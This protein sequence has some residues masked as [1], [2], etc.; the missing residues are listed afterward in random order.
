MNVYTPPHNSTELLEPQMHQE[1][2]VHLPVLVIRK[3]ALKLRQY[4]K[5]FKNP[6][7]AIKE[8]I[9]LK[10]SVSQCRSEVISILLALAR[11]PDRFKIDENLYISTRFIDTK[12]GVR[13]SYHNFCQSWGER[14][15]I[16]NPAISINNEKF[17]N[18]HET[19]M[20]A[21]VFESLIKMSE[22]E[23]ELKNELKTLEE[24]KRV[25]A[26]YSDEKL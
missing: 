2:A 17:L 23:Y 15:T 13:F 9:D 3:S 6:S 11:E 5:C 4:I 19:M 22:N 10:Y 1:I 16:R 14:N 24:Q 21:R 20:M 7:T 25:F 12:T 8:I 26:T 18:D